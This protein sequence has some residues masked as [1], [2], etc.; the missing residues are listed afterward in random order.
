MV[1]CALAVGAGGLLGAGVALGVGGT[2]SLLSWGDDGYGELGNGTTN[3]TGFD[4]PGAVSAGA[5]PAGTRFTQ[6][7]AGGGYP[8]NPSFG[9]ALSSTGALFSWGSEEYGQLGNGVTANT[10]TTVPGAV[11]A[12]AIPAGTKMTQIAASFYTGV[13]L[14]STG[15]VYDWGDNNV[16]QLGDGASGLVS[17]VPVAVSAGAIPAG[18]TITQIAAGGEFALALSSAGKVYGWGDDSVG[19]LGD[20]PGGS[21]NVP[22]AVSA[23]AMPAGTTITQIVAGE[24]F[25]LALS[26]TGKVYGWGNDSNG[27]LG[28]GGSGAPNAPV[29]LA[30]GVIPAGTRITQLAAGDGFALA[31]SSTGKLYAWGD[32]AQGQLGDGTTSSSVPVAVAAGAIPAGAKIIQITANSVTAMALSSSG[33]VYAWGI[34]DKGELGNGASATAIPY[35][36]APVAASLPAGTTIDALSTGSG[37]ADTLA[38]VGDLALST[39]SLPAGTVGLPYS[40]AVSATGGAG[41]DVWS[42]SGLPAGLSINASS[43]AITGTPAAAGNATV[44][45]SVS[46]GDGLSVSASLAIDV[47]S[48]AAA[49]ATVNPRSGAIAFAQPLTGAGTLSWTLTFPNGSDGVFAAK[50]H[51]A[52]KPKCS[53]TQ[54]RLKGRCRPAAVAFGSGSTSVT[55]AGTATFTVTPGASALKALRTALRHHRGVAVS[56]TLTFQSALG[57]SPVSETQTVLDKLAKPKHKRHKKHK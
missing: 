28:D 1:A 10:S 22:V 13:A 31:L 50:R 24:D 27:Q 23:G 34:N 56:A 11:S 4:L 39:G 51:K 5:I 52:H 48:F 38:I 30:A 33:Q 44:T 55:A 42:A 40:A 35:A 54:V 37:A 49:S 36:T 45:L 16:G 32:G 12:G 20:A 21:S 6:V 26:S 57:G 8:Y 15:H 9:L 47:T 53:A 17:N 41:G 14:S 43:G 7:A 25:A 18:V 19:Q 3:T 46:D 29:A 2:G